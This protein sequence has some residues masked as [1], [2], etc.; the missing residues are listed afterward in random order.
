MLEKHEVEL[1]FDNTDMEYISSILDTILTATDNGI[2]ESIGLNYINKYYPITKIYYDGIR[3]STVIKIILLDRACL[4]SLTQLNQ[5]QLLDIKYNIDIIEYQKFI[6]NMGSSKHL[7]WRH[8]NFKK[9]TSGDWVDE[10][11]DKTFSFEKGKY[12]V[13]LTSGE[14]EIIKFVI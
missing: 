1:M 4:E 14:E 6:N 8:N 2:L 9:F 11:K 7:D 5:H 13:K 3:E 12:T 10:N